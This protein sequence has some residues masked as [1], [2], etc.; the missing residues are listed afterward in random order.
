MALI[1]KGE[2][3]QSDFSEEG[4]LSVDENQGG[5]T[6]S[7]TLFGFVNQIPKPPIKRNAFVGTSYLPIHSFYKIG[8]R[9]G[10]GTWGAVYTA[11]ERCSSI[12]R[13]AKKIPKQCTGE[14]FRF[15]QEMQLLST[16]D[17][18]NI[19]R[20]YES[21]EDYNSI[22]L[23]MELC[24]GGELFNRLTQVNIFPERVAAHLLKQILS[25]V[26]YC[27]SKGIVHRDL[28]PENFLFV[29]HPSQISCHKCNNKSNENLFCI[30]NSVLARNTLSDSIKSVPEN[31]SVCSKVSMA[32][33]A[34]P[35]S[36]TYLGLTPSS[37]LNGS[38]EITSLDLNLNE[39]RN[40]I[41]CHCFDIQNPLKLIDFG[42][43]KRIT[44]TGKLRT[45]VGTLYYI[46]P[47]ILLGKG[48][49]EKCDIWSVGVMAHILLCGVPPFIGNT[50]A[51]IIER[52]R[53]GSIGF[54]EFIWSEISPLAKEFILLL[55]NKNP[56]ER[57][58]AF[59]ALQHPWLRIW[60]PPSI[61]TC[62]IGML[63]KVVVWP[64]H[65]QRVRLYKMRA[66]NS[67]SD[68]RIKSSISSP[69]FSSNSLK[70]IEMED[71]TLLLSANRESKY[72]N[73]DNNS[74]LL[75]NRSDT[76]LSSNLTL[77]NIQRGSSH[78]SSLLRRSCSTPLL[79]GMNNAYPNILSIDNFNISLGKFKSP[80]TRKM[81]FTN[82]ELDRQPTPRTKAT[83]NAMLNREYAMLSPPC[84]PRFHFGCHC[85]NTSI[86]AKVGQQR[87]TSLSLFSP[88]L[89]NFRRSY[90]C[91]LDDRFN[92]LHIVTK[93]RIS[94]ESTH[95]DIVTASS[96][97]P[98][99]LS[100]P[101]PSFTSSKYNE[102]KYIYT[103]ADS[104][105]QMMQY[106]CRTALNSP[107]NNISGS[108]NNFVK[109]PMV[110]SNVCDAE[111][112]YKLVFSK[113]STLIYESL[114]G[115]LGKWE[116]F[117]SYSLLKRVIL[118]SIALRL[119]ESDD[120][121]PLREQFSNLDVAADGVLSL[122]EL[123]CVLCFI[124]HIRFIS[125][126]INFGDRTIHGLLPS[127]Q[128]SFSGN[129]VK[130][131]NMGNFSFK[132]LNSNLLIN[133][134]NSLIPHS[135]VYIDA[136]DIEE[137]E[138]NSE[139]EQHDKDLN[140]R[141][142]GFEEIPQN[143]MVFDT[144]HP[145][146]NE[147]LFSKMDIICEFDI[148][149]IIELNELCNRIEGVFGIID[150]DQSGA[151]EFSEFMAASMPPEIYLNN[152]NIVKAVF[153]NFD[154]DSDGKVSVQDI[155]AS[156][157]WEDDII[158][159]SETVS[160]QQY[161]QYLRLGSNQPYHRDD[162]TDDKVQYCAHIHWTEI[163]LTE[164]CRNGKQY[165]DFNDFFE[166]LIN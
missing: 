129:K 144:K 111:E 1:K 82:L 55:L 94:T 25:A 146:N 105:Q 136:S 143:S 138:L 18:P 135:N 84:D 20:L 53:K 80:V 106:Y 15:R 92:M 4:G 140:C 59:Q 24:K 160:N 56:L 107:S 165:L 99:F 40:Q 57:I 5:R 78:R 48:Y 116:Q 163:F 126:Y 133:S 34:C 29:K 156:F 90:S 114:L 19:A 130:S 35:G 75:K 142:K 153:R 65:Q 149:E 36:G 72:I 95:M 77:N 134:I 22:Y 66:S 131:G 37:S 158:I 81:S 125:R 119:G 91:S 76:D 7:S 54:N 47:E 45:C 104:N 42:L 21:F 2:D 166:F 123:Q 157:G 150:Q 121:I 73:T 31:S 69:S 89:K 14:L 17:H 161:E 43:A 132:E 159:C 113:N 6:S 71:E 33:L 74:I 27:N 103:N 147:K 155:L 122:A 39:C 120:Y 112:L 87:S 127:M 30:P 118:V 26:S 50:D 102:G 151:W 16:L 9:V 58:S 86:I 68:L 23:I 154:K 110:K 79:Y 141:L 109:L 11:E 117:C 67:I 46:A 51:E 97:E 28:K 137:Y 164:C 61:P 148:N 100:N 162:G 83:I 85:G 108:R 128:S 63:N 124:W 52:V 38:A 115:L 70:T 13:A 60:D 62:A 49:D 98:N 12:M 10:E 152:I 8:E 3:D 139:E 93:N 32:A 64:W 145:S 96:D 44:R 88:S 41:P 101:I